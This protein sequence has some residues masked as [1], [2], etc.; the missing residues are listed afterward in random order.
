MYAERADEPTLMSEVEYLAFA[1]V[2]E[3]RY[4]YRQGQIYAMTGA[5][6][7]HGVITVNV[8]TQ[9]NLQLADRDCTVTSSDTRIHIAARR[10]YRYP[11][12][13]VFCG[14][15]AY[16][17][18]RRDTIINPALIV[19]V[20]SPATALRDRN[21]KLL[22]YT[23]IETLHAYLLVA[24]DEARVERYLRQE[25]GDWLYTVV[26]GLDESIALPTLGCTLALADIYRK[27]DWDQA[28]EGGS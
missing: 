27:V 2:Q 25:S 12:V 11:D 23:Q 28:S 16:L 17:E 14:E 9:L 26:R 21:D 19:E 24:Q 3:I 8:S 5:S 20:L 7:R 1:D 13:T 22:E 15:P 4:E 18:G 6:V 10:S